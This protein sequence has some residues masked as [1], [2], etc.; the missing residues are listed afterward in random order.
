MSL[1]A[2]VSLF[3][4]TLVLGFSSSAFAA[5]G[6]DP[7]AYQN[8]RAGVSA[9]DGQNYS[10]AIIDFGEALRR[11]PLA[12]E[13][14]YN[15]GLSF[16]QRQENPK[17]LES[18]RLAIEYARDDETRFRAHFNTAVILTAEKK[19]EEALAHYQEA[20]NAKPDSFETK[21]NIEMLVAQKDQQDQK[22]EQDKKDQDKKDQDKDQKQKD[23]DKKDGKGEQEQKQDQEQ[24]K[25]KQEQTEPDKGKEKQKKPGEY[26]KPKPQDFKSQELTPGDVNKI[27]DEIKQQEQRIRAE[28]QRKETKERPR[29]KP[30]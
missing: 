14:H 23:Q 17:A 5:G 4:A 7:R 16:Y 9:F 20:L 29:E 1:P 26:E 18:F 2:K 11:E 25:G 22:K 6:S 21:I 24:G 3:L 27:L 28:F 30:W 10:E 13:I 19:F 8:N 15:L 12:G